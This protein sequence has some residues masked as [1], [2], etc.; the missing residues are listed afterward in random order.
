MSYTCLLVSK[1]MQLCWTYIG[2]ELLGHGVCLVRLF[3]K[4]WHS[5]LPSPVGPLPVCLDSWTQRSRF[6]CSTTS[7][8]T[9]ITSHIQNWVLFLLWL[10]LFVLSGLISPL[11]SSSVLGTYQPGEFIFQCRIFCLFILF[12][13]FSRQEYWSGLPLPS[14]VDHVLSEFS[15]ITH[16]PW[17]AL[18][19]MAGSWFHW[20]RQGCGPCDQIG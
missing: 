17:V 2:M 7:D 6:L 12:M 5:L 11:I 16:P 9:S 14:P 19:S 8:F 1:C 4:C 20:V 10:C 18:R 13:G 3:L 15:T